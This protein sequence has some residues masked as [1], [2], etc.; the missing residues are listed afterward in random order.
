[1]TGASALDVVLF[2][3]LPYAALVLFFFGTIAR[4]RTSPFSFSSLSSQFL[5]NKRHFWS[6][7]PFH[8][9]LLVVLAGHVVAFLVPRAVLAW[10]EVP[11]RLFILEV[12]SFAFG[13]L[14]FIGLFNIVR[15]RLTS[16]RA[17]MT[18]T[19]TDWILYGLLML[20]VLTGL[21][22]AVSN[23]WG[24]SWFAAV[25]SPYLW[26]IVRFAP[27]VGWVAPLPF[28]VKLHIVGL[29]ALLGLFP[30]TRLVHVLVVPNP[31]L[32]RRPQVVRW[33]GI[34]RTG[35]PNAVARK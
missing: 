20:Q 19:P 9:G 17:K 4:Y 10:N 7:V 28:T 21:H 6:Q 8:Y 15:R 30:F 18:T 35:A 11:L 34:R 29:W 1:M 5:D 14:A 3:A 2:V 24:S 16:P 23:T 25:L 22:I 31:Y 12:S 33:Y 26:S 13:L 27:D 32:W